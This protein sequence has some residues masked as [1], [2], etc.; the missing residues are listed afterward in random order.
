MASAQY[1]RK[2][3]VGFV[4]IGI[5]VL[6]AIGLI[7]GTAVKYVPQLRDML[8][9]KLVQ[10]EEE[11]KPKE[12]PPPP[13][14]FKP[15]V[16]QAPIMDMPQV[17]APPTA[18]QVPKE[19]PKVV[20]APKPKAEP[21]P[22]VAVRLTKNGS[23]KLSDACSSYYPSASRR[24]SEEGSVVL[25]MFVNASGKVTE[26][27]VETSSGIPR[28]D[29]AAQKCVMSVG[30]GVFEPQKVGNEAVSAWFRIKWT[31]RLAS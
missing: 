12:P 25:A 28:L 24:L 13:P 7:A 27:K 6:F 23:A 31:W 5:H 17:V 19:A 8:E 9:A 30:T 11:D 16:V 14:D 1:S 20:E 2:T 15:P 18:I 10:H 22:I 26:T 29:E 3:I 4:V 21:P